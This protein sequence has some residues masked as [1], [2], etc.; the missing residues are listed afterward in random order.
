MPAVPVA[1]VGIGGLGHFAIQFAKKAGYHVVAVTHSPEKADLARELGADDV[2]SDGEGL[3]AAGGAD[4][5]MHT[6]SNHAIVAGAMAGLRPWG[7]VVMMGIATDEM[8]LPAL[9]LVS[10]SYQIIGSAHNGYEYLAE[11]LEIVA[12]GEVTPRIE[13]FPKERIAEAYDRAASGD[14]RFKAVVTY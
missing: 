10:N 5:I 11:A 8:T 4:L 7:K 13:V 12:S 9:P 14:V 2:V 1:V 3:K 6:S